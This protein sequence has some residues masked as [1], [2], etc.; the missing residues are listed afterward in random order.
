MSEALLP[1]EKALALIHQS[2][3]PGGSENRPLL[4]TPGFVLDEEIRADRDLPPFY[5]SQVDGYALRT[6]EFLSG[7]REF[8]V[9]GTIYAGES[10][11]LTYA[12]GTS[13]KIMTGGALPEGW[14]AVV[15]RENVELRGEE[16]HIP[17]ESMEEWFNVSRQGEDSRQGDLLA[18]P[19]R[20]VD[21][22]LLAVAAS[23]GKSTLRVK[24]KPT[25]ALIT[26]GDE[27]ISV[28]N[29]PSPVQ[30]RDANTYSLQT[31]MGH[32]GIH[33]LFVERV[34][35]DREAL[36]QAMSK[37]LQADILLLTGGVSMGDTDY[38]PALLEE[39][40]V[41]KVFHR[42]KVKPGRPIW[43][44]K[45]REGNAVFGLPGNPMSCMAGFKIFVEPY[46]R[47]FMSLP[48]QEPLLLPLARDKRKKHDLEE[49]A[50]AR[51][52]ETEEGSRLVHVE[53]HGSGDF[54]SILQSTGLLVHPAEQP[55]LAKGEKARFYYWRAP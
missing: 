3:T 9:V 48:L 14:D 54:V 41:K 1:A 30:I 26:T 19:P 53:H 10:S 43:F 24:R 45:G 47:R 49:Y 17:R 2:V 12:P 25:M 8:R 40:G 16:V 27:I 52:E 50:I 51:V 7:R 33:P 34:G 36:R 44:G 23:V 21:A 42:L 29:T 35:D 6:E 37:G 32:Y 31:L 55:L 15:K 4:E 13:V 46:L 20:A 28:E 22:A 38:V 5:R 18:A 11:S 39:L